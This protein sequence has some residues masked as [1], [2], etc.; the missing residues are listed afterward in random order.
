MFSGY[1]LEHFI[2]LCIVFFFQYF[3]F[4]FNFKEWNF[5]QRFII[6]V[7]FRD[8][9]PLSLQRSVESCLAM[10]KRYHQIIEIISVYQ[11]L[12]WHT[13]TGNIYEWLLNMLVVVQR[14]RVDM[15]Y[16]FMFQVSS[17][18]TSC[19]WRLEFSWEKKKV[20]TGEGGWK[21]QL[22]Y[23]PSWNLNRLWFK[24]ELSG[25]PSSICSLYAQCICKSLKT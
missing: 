5:T 18:L 16:L 14:S 15:K 25:F 24:H 21:W 9:Y 6:E 8:P 17:F 2:F 4:V 10:K 1:F 19:V 11:I 22:A 3:I 20:K 7:S 13:E 23:F 12:F